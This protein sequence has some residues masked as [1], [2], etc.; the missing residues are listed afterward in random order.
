M[1]GGNG[2]PEVCTSSEPVEE[3]GRKLSSFHRDRQD[4]IKASRWRGC[5]GRGQGSEKFYQRMRAPRDIT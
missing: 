1:E 4:S 5:S 2:N 3:R